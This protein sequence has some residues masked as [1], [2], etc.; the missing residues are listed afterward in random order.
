MPD[1]DEWFEE[2]GREYGVKHYKGHDIYYNFY[3]QLSKTSKV[4]LRGFGLAYSK[5]LHF[6]SF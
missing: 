3:K 4:Y 1:M 2:D 5:T 6:T